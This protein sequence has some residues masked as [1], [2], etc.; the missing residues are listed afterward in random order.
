VLLEAPSAGVGG[1]GPFTTAA[2]DVFKRGC[3]D[4]A[5]MA[6]SRSTTSFMLGRLSTS[7]V[8]QSYDGT[9]RVQDR[10]QTLTRSLALCR[11]ASAKMAEHGPRLCTRGRP[12]S[13]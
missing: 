12:S 13:G 11:S 7:F 5:S 2:A 1:A 6:V 4:A 8:R 9:A 10:T 3:L